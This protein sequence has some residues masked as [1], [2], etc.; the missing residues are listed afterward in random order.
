MGYAVK[1]RSSLRAITIVAVMAVMLP[2][3][4][5]PHANL[6]SHACTHIRK[7]VSG[8]KAKGAAATPAAGCMAKCT[9]GDFDAHCA[10]GV[11]QVSDL[12]LC[13][14]L[15]AEQAD[16]ARLTRDFYQFAREVQAADEA[17]ER[18]TMAEVKQAEQRARAMLPPAS[19]NS[20]ARASLC[21]DYT[22]ASDAVTKRAACEASGGVAGAAPCPTDHVVGTCIVESEGQSLHYYTTGGR[23]RTAEARHECEKTGGHWMDGWTFFTLDEPSPP[24]HAR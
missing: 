14:R 18:Q 7:L 22:K 21:L 1:G 6:C 23:P 17:R 10:L 16:T 20:L 24:P 11:K 4:A 2:V 13:I 9:R 8:S 5:R 15:A 3:N 19:C 12:E